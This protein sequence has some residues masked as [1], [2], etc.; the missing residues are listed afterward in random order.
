MTRTT[1]RDRVLRA[2]VFLLDGPDGP[3]ACRWTAQPTHAFREVGFEALVHGRGLG[4][5]GVFDPR[6]GRFRLPAAWG[7]R[8]VGT[9]AVLDAGDDLD[10]DAGLIVV[11]RPRAFPTQF[12]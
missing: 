3:R 5:F 10:V 4:D 1:A 9:D 12:A 7:D 8:Q 6:T 11:D 2:R